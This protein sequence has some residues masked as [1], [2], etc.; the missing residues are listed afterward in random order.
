MRSSQ[1]LA[2]SQILEA[3]KNII[4]SLD[5]YNDFIDNQEVGQVNNKVHLLVQSSILRWL[6][7]SRWLFYLRHRNKQRV[8]ENEE[9]EIQSKQT[10]K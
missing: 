7:S 6:E 4:G 8:K 10:N 3:I 9:K 5:N 1:A 2:H